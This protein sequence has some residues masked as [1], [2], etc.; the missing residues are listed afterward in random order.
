MVID[1]I[2]ELIYNDIIIG[3][4]EIGRLGTK[5]WSGQK[6]SIF[7]CFHAIGFVENVFPVFITNLIPAKK[8]RKQ[9]KM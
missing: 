1:W 8:Y 6:R 3:K 4:N 9:K 7:F 5:D 2:F